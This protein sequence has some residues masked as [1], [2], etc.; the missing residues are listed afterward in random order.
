MS[1]EPE[2]NGAEPVPWAW[3]KAARDIV[4]AEPRQQPES[5]PVQLLPWLFLSDMPSVLKIDRLEELGITA[6]LTTNKVFRDEDLWAMTATIADRD[7]QHGYAGG[8]D[9]VGYDMMKYHWSDAKQFIQAALETPNAKVVSHCAAGT[10]RSALIAGAAML[11]FGTNREMTFLDVI[12]IL[13]KERGV[14][15]NNVWFIRQL[16]EFAQKKK[17]LGPRPD[18]Y[19]DEPVP[20]SQLVF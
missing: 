2:T 16:A 19:S 8:V 10:N 4:K 7:M 13:K 5:M 3:I 14:V 17:R 12:R 15:L 18:G 20:K 1:N 6:V 11:E 9:I